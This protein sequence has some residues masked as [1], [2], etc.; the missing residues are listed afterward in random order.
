[1]LKMEE[2]IL[3]LGEEI[4]SLQNKAK[5]LS[6]EIENIILSNKC[7]NIVEPTILKMLK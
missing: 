5:E 2:E 1:M 3:K 4:R 6:I 7:T